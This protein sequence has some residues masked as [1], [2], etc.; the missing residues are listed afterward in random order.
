V[1]LVFSSILFLFFFLPIVLAIYFVVPVRLRNPVL[2]A[3]SLLFYV[4][5]EP[6]YAGVM[7][8]SILVNYGFG[9][10]VKARPRLI[11]FAAV[12]VNIGLLGFF[13]YANF[14]VDNFN[15][16][17]EAS[18]IV[19][20]AIALPVGISFFTFHALSYVIDIHRGKSPPQKN[21]FDLALYIV[22]FPQLIAGPIVRYH[23]IADQLRQRTVTAE[24]FA[25]GI[26]R[27]VIGLA[28]K[29]L[30]A[31]TVAQAADQI[32]ALDTA[33]IGS[34]VAWLGIVCYT[35]QIYFDFSGY[36]DMAIGLALMFGFRFPE[37][38][39][40]PYAARSV[41]DFWRRWHI[42]LSTWFRDY[43]YIPLGGNRKGVA[44]IYLNLYIVFFLTGLWH[45]AS[46]NFVVWGLL[47]GTLM[48]VERLGFDRV[49]AWLWLPLQHAYTLL[50]VMIAWVFFR[51]ETLPQAVSY[52]G[53]MFSFTPANPVYPLNLYLN[54]YLVMT[55]AAGILF[56]FPAA[57]LLR[58]SEL[59]PRFAL[60]RLAAMMAL[61]VLSAMALTVNTYNP[62]IY[63]RF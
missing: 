26:H 51:A 32:F 11:L 18:P 16:L 61:F 8:F 49:L 2:L 19:F 25:E 40:Y 58:Q 62:F 1:V 5:G 55:L 23:A 48:V 63:F 43:V 42:T 46:W 39:N 50:V 3:A 34:G 13:K 36:S 30:I 29:V 24:G 20:P 54:P 12:I 27:F 22:L 41:Q 38:F 57:T 53:R 56:S 33:Q 14:L 21:L 44:R 52:L 4:W 7:L 15:T 9:L 37:N 47:H 10:G 60:L 59:T 28:K 45:G 17:L 35:L 6:V 31:N